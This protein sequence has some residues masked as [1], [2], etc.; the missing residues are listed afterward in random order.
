MISIKEGNRP[1][2]DSQDASAKGRV[3]I[4]T[5]DGLDPNDA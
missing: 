4:H 1:P 2:H 5:L 3:L